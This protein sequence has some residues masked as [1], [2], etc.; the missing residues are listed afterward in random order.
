MHSRLCANYWYKME[1]VF[2]KV[3]WGIA[4]VVFLKNYFPKH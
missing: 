2:S 3:W 1:V 4:E